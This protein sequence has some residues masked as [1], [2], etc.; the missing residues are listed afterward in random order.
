MESGLLKKDFSTF[1]I[2]ILLLSTPLLPLAKAEKSFPSTII[3]DYVHT[4]YQLFSGVSLN[5]SSLIISNV[6]VN[7]ELGYWS[8]D[9]VPFDVTISFD[10]QIWKPD[11]FFGLWNPRI[12]VNTGESIPEYPMYD[13]PAFLGPSGPKYEWQGDEREHWD[14]SYPGT[15]G[16]RTISG[17]IFL[18]SPIPKYGQSVKLKVYF[19][20]DTYY[21]SAR[22]TLDEMRNG[23]I[24]LYPF[25]TVEVRNSFSIRPQGLAFGNVYGSETLTKAVILSTSDSGS[26]KWSISSPEPWISIKPSDGNTSIG[27]VVVEVTVNSDGLSTGTYSSE[28]FFTSNAGF[29]FLPVTLNVTSDSTIPGKLTK[30]INAGFSGVVGGSIP[31]SGSVENIP[32]SFITGLDI[33]AGIALPVILTVDY[34]DNLKPDSYAQI[35]VSAEGSLGGRVWMNLVGYIE[36]KV[37]GLGF[38]F[39]FTQADL[40]NWLTNT[41]EGWRIDFNRLITFKVP[42]L[43]EGYKNEFNTVPIPLYNFEFEQGNLTFGVSF[44][45]ACFVDS[46]LVGNVTMSGNAIENPTTSHVEW[47]ANQNYENSIQVKENARPGAYLRIASSDVQYIIPNITFLLSKVTFHASLGSYLGLNPAYNRPFDASKIF[48]DKFGA[49]IAQNLTRAIE[50]NFIVETSTPSL[51]NWAYSALSIERGFESGD[52]TVS[53]TNGGDGDVQ[54]ITVEVTNSSGLTVTPQTQFIDT[55]NG[56][57]VGRATFSVYATEKTTPKD[58]TLTFEVSYSDSRGIKHSQTYQAIV[59]VTSNLAR[60]NLNDILI[61]MILSAISLIACVSY[62]RVRKQKHTRA[63]PFS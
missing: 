4:S 57:K 58:Y 2:A 30:V 41:E 63:S 18:L 28:V 49:S 51:F 52:L 38:N 14:K 61:V 43:R 36:G 39:R 37:A 7:V 8:E 33:S 22:E 13:F 17:S 45:F 53:F 47:T 5:I 44:T 34:P 29:A 19:G 21:T 32:F 12:I 59:T 35:S 27:R 11:N 26:F 20:L 48:S 23:D 31:I 50:S 56:G 3:G 15:Y 40:Y 24:K 54:A 55:L 42:L 6:R 46:Y 9:K 25:G 16:S 1:V 62:V 60:E 10:Y